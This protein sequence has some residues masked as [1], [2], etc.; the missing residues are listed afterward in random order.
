MRKLF[1]SSLLTLALAM[2]FA[3]GCQNEPAKPAAEST[4]APAAEPAAPPADETAAPAASGEETPPPP[5]AADE[6]APADEG[7]ADSNS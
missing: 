2:L 7:A 6:A 4:P 1:V 5:P 3:A